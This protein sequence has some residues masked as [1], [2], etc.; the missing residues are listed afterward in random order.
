VASEGIGEAALKVM[1]AGDGMIR[2]VA[3]FQGQR[4]SFS[5]YAW[6]DNNHL[7]FVSYQRLP[8]SY[9]GAP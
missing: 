2:T 8:A 4:D 7:A 6:G 3:S 1:V 5:T 9:G